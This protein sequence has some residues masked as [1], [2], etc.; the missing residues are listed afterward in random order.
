MWYNVSVTDMSLT[1]LDMLPMQLDMSLA[2]RDMH[3]AV[4]SSKRLRV[5]CGS[6]LRKRS[7][8]EGSL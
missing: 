4:R 3:L 7:P 5:N 2:R 1:Q 8:P 6:L